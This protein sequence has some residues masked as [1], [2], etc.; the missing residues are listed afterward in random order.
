[1]GL[2]VE[3]IRQDFPVLQKQFNG[4]PIIYFDN[5]CMAL[6]P[7]QVI[8]KIREYYTEY[9]ACGDRSLHKLG[10]RVDEEIDKAKNT[11][12]KFINAKSEKEIILTKNTTEGINLVANSLGLKNSDIVLGTDKE[13]N[14]NLLPWQKLAAKGVKYDYVKTDDNFI[15]NL[16]QKLDRNVRV[17]AMVHTSNLDG[18]SIPAKE[19]VKIAHDNGSLVLLDGAQAAPHK[20]VDVRKLDTDFFAFSG[21]K[22]MGPT[23]TGILYGKEHLLEKLSPFIVGGGTVIDTTH[24][25][26]KFEELPQKFEAG[27]QH[28]AGIIGLGEAANYIMKVGRDNIERHETALNQRITE[29]LSGLVDIIGPN[30]SGKRSGIFS[31][32]YGKADPHEIAMLLDQLE[33]IC[34]RSGAHCVHSWFNAH[35]LRGS[36]RASLYLYNTA[37]ECGKFVQTV[38]RIIDIVK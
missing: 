21:H 5:A 38:K 3:K 20:E 17:V 6:R 8:E 23:G 4:K 10:K 11:L 18:T 29:G 7:A 36:V 32:N 13:H 34:V 16:K 31:F 33:N 12:K 9:P 22:M 26:A 30:D 24:D 25:S 15:E 28:Y 35:N 27:L 37:E 14:S 19:I 1:M 2:N